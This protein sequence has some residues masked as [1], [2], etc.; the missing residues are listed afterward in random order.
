MNQTI[1][2]GT[3]SG[4]IITICYIWATILYVVMIAVILVFVYKR[5][6]RCG[7]DDVIEDIELGPMPQRRTPHTVW[8]HRAI[9]ISLNE[10]RNICHEAE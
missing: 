10:K 9:I 7:Y 2:L 5:I 6:R 1:I 8:I 3:P 4:V